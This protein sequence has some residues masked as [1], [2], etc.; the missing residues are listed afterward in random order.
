[1]WGK[2]V[3]TITANK[4]W[5]E[6][7]INEVGSCFL[8]L[9]IVKQLD[10]VH[11]DDDEVIIEM[12]VDDLIDDL[13][14]VGLN[15]GRV[16]TQVVSPD[17]RVFLLDLFQVPDEYRKGLLFKREVDGK[18][19]CIGI[20]KNESVARAKLRNNYD[21]MMNMSK[22]LHYNRPQFIGDCLTRSYHEVP[23]NQR[24]LA[25]VLDNGVWKREVFEL[26][27]MFW[28]GEARFLP[29]LQLTGKR[30]SFDGLNSLVTWVEC[31]G[32]L[33]VNV[34]APT[35]DAAMCAAQRMQEII[36]QS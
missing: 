4:Q 33:R 32:F 34:K 11:E 14:Q 3:Y 12:G 19:I 13:S 7:F 31:F 36:V 17:E 18:L 35:Y 26:D 8:T 30:F 27:L 25:D 9:E 5:F 1:V 15:Q 22:V 23:E 16:D 29:F 24:H 6:Q 28:K 10:G 20:G 2:S 21:H